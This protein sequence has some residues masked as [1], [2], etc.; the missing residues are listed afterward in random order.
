MPMPTYFR[1]PETGE[2]YWNYYDMEFFEGGHEWDPKT[3]T[4]EPVHSVKC[5]TCGA[6]ATF[7]RDEIT[8]LIVDAD[9]TPIQDTFSSA[10]PPPKHPHLSEP[11]PFETTDQRPCI[12]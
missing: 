12:M 7:A 11:F 8:E 2:G 1:N 6:T 5:A 10:E 9:G 4:L 3:V